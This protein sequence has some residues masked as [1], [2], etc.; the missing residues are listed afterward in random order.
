[1]FQRFSARIDGGAYTDFQTK[2]SAFRRL[3]ARASI[4]GVAAG[5]TTFGTRGLDLQSF[6]LGG[7]LQLGAY[8]RNELLGN[9]YFF[10][11]RLPASMKLARFT[12]IRADKRPSQMVVRPRAYFLAGFSKSSDCAPRLAMS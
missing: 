11:G 5:G 7:P 12:A 4:F 1:M 6:S 9:Q 3:S 2:T 10:P 8:G